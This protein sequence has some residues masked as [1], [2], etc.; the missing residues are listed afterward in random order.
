MRKAIFKSR[1]GRS[2]VR[3]DKELPVR[4]RIYGQASAKKRKAVLRGRLL[5]NDFRW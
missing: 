4:F 2:Y 3:I 5:K 1:D